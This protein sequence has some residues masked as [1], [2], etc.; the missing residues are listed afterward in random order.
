MDSWYKSNEF[1]KCSTWWQALITFIGTVIFNGVYSDNVSPPVWRALSSQPS[2]FQCCFHWNQTRILILVGNTLSE[3]DFK[4]TLFPLFLLSAFRPIF[5]DV[6]F[7]TRELPFYHTESWGKGGVG[8]PLMV[9]SM[10]KEQ[11]HKIPPS[12]YNV[13]WMHWLVWPSHTSCLTVIG[14]NA[15]LDAY[16]TRPEG[17]SVLILIFTR[18]WRVKQTV[19]STHCLPGALISFDLWHAAK[20]YHDGLDLREWE[21]EGI[22]S[23]SSLFGLELDCF[24]LCLWHLTKR[25]L[26]GSPLFNLF[27][28]VACTKINQS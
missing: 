10:L 6:I 18:T 8:W 25:K 17:R 27:P 16:K 24:L 22:P 7:P 4:H 20:V 9:N 11:S 23:L 14:N 13:I 21:N 19:A 26:N 12:H 5:K 2:A 3:S 28:P 15:G 1:R